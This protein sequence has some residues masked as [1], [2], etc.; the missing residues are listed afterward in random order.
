MYYTQRHFSVYLKYVTYIL[1]AIIKNPCF[2]LSSNRINTKLYWI[3][4]NYM[5]E[6]N[7]NL[8]IEIFEN[9]IYTLVVEV[10]HIFFYNIY[11]FSAVSNDVLFGNKIKFKVLLPLNGDCWSSCN[12]KFG[13]LLE[14]LTVCHWLSL[15][16]CPASKIYKQRTDMSA[17]KSL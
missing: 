13:P 6:I 14:N 5:L 16:F 12:F 10:E 8:L 17:Q 3:S 7:Q 11:A 2:I 4:L 9:C 15:T 1:E